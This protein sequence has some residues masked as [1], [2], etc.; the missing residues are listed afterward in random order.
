M[1]LVKSVLQAALLAAFQKAEH[2]KTGQ[3]Q[4]NLCDDLSTAI[5][6]YIKTATVTGTCSTPSGPGTTTSTTIE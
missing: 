1:A 3:S 2:D 4:A 6:T 5:D